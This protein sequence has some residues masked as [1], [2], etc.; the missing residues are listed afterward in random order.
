MVVSASRRPLLAA[1]PQLSR[2]P[3]PKGAAKGA[4]MSDTPQLGRDAPMPAGPEA[5]VL[6]RVPNP[7]PQDIY[8]ARF[9][10]PEFTTLCPVTGQPDFAHLVIDYAPAAWLI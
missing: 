7:H 1:P 9:T 2:L 5:A 3:A 10:Q 8:L 6:D 4:R